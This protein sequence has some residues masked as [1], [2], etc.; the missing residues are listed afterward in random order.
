MQALRAD[1][2][3]DHLEKLIVAKSP[4]QVSFLRHV[5]LCG[6]ATQRRRVEHH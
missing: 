6:Y 2:L 1:I 4:S 5:S 3:R